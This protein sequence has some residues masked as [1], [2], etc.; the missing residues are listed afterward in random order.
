LRSSKAELIQSI[1]RGLRPYPGKE[2]C[3]I[4]DHG[5][6]VERMWEPLSDIYENG[7]SVLD[8]G[9]RKD[10]KKSKAEERKPMKCGKCAHVHAPRPSCPACG[11]VYKKVAS[12]I[13]HQAGTLTKFAGRVTSPTDRKEVFSQFL[14][15][16]RERKYKDGWAHHAFREYTGTEPPFVP[17][18][19]PQEPSQKLLNWTRSRMIR[20]A[21]GRA[22]QQQSA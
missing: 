13:Q 17:Q 1:G 19:Q 6:S 3:I 22:K 14:H 15:I 11:H 20:R 12:K 4:L 16:A 2:K 18:P 5:G 10:T 21:K 7:I 8:D 9:S